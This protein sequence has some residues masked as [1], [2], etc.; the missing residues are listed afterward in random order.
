MPPG[1]KQYSSLVCRPSVDICLAAMSACTAIRDGLV[2]SYSTEPRA[3]CLRDVLQ[4]VQHPEMLPTAANLAEYSPFVASRRPGDPPV[5]GG[6]AHASASS[7]KAAVSVA[8]V[9]AVVAAA[10]AVPLS[11]WDQDEDMEEYVDYLNNLGAAAAAQLPEEGEGYEEDEGNNAWGGMCVK[12]AAEGAGPS[13]PAGASPLAALAAADVV[14]ANIQQL[15]WAKLE[16]LF[17]R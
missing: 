11:D 8:K 1:H 15:T 9:A 4:L 5:S 10:A 17:P 3:N 7:S 13:R 16:K 2:N 12:A 14:V 6:A